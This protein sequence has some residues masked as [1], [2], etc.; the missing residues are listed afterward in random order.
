MKIKHYDLM[1][2]TSETHLIRTAIN[3]SKIFINSYNRKSKYVSIIDYKNEMYLLQ[4]TLLKDIDLIDIKLDI[5]YF[6]KVKDISELNYK[7]SKLFF[8]N[9]KEMTV[10]VIG[11]YEEDLFEI[12]VGLK[13]YMKKQE[14]EEL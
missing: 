8:F 9:E 7:E 6:I 11:L 5:N 4:Y 1:S 10:D 3:S 13:R 14:K 2:N 12:Y